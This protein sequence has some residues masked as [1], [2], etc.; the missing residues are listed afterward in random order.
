MFE[1]VSDLKEA[2]DFIKQLRKIKMLL[3]VVV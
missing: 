1:D 3:G 2:Y